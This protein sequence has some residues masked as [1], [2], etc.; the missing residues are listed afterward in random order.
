MIRYRK[1]DAELV[2]SAVKR[3]RYAP[4]GGKYKGPNY[5]VCKCAVCSLIR[6]YARAERGRK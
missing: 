5:S 2:F 3:W 1:R 6:A 4:E